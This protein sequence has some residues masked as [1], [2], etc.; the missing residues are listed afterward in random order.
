MNYTHLF[1]DLD[2]T[3]VDTTEGVLKCVVHAL[4]FMHFPVPDGET[5]KK[6]MGPPLTESFATFA[7]MTPDQALFAEKKYRD[8]YRRYGKR[9]IAEYPG[10]RELL[11]DLKAAGYRLSVATSKLERTAREVLGNVGYLPLFETVSG[12]SPDGNISSK[13]QVL[14]QAMD[15]LRI[16]DRSSVLM[17]GDRKYDILGAKKVSLHAVG[18]YTGNAEEGELENAGADAVVRSVSELRRLLLK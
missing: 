7:G 4:N 2:G 15:R 14:L 12:S 8:R 9:E 5:L 6:Y 18:I 16:T 17:I 3:L 13:E 10:M 11:T 1:F